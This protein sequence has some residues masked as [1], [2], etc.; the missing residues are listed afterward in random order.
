MAGRMTK[1]IIAGISFLVCGS[2]A[3][4]AQQVIDNW[5]ITPTADGKSATMACTNPNTN[6]SVEA[7]IEIS[8]D[9]AGAA[10]AGTIKFKSG[11]QRPMTPGEV[12]FLFVECKAENAYWN[13]RQNQ[14]S[15]TN[16]TSGIDPL[17]T[18]FVGQQVRAISKEG[19]NYFGTLS[20]LPSSPDWFALT[21]KTSRVLFYRNSVKEIQMLK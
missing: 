15:I 4:F 13:F 3:I 16:I 12:A 17:P 10:T 21:I 11:L 18:G 9:G 14:G 6:L 2:Q 7:E 20:M 19:A 5:K 1:I 8:V